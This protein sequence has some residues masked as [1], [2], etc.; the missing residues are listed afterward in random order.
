MKKVIALVLLTLLLLPGCSSKQESNL[1][2]DGVVQEVN[3][4]GLLVT[5]DDEVGFDKAS[6]SY[7]EDIVM[8]FEPAVGQEVQIEI[9]SQIRESYPVGVTAVKII[10]INEVALP[11]YKKITAEEAKEMMDTQEVIILDVRTQAEYDEGHIEGA[12][13][14]PNTELE[15][16]AET[17]LPDKDKTILVYCRSGNRSETA[18]RLL[19]DMGYSAVYDFGGIIDWPYETVTE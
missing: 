12:L 18:S 16:K 15:D 5:T 10:L 17:L 6:V 11:Q 9:L 8:D 2:F 7:A 3:E 13:L 14:I 1:V 4:S 19:V